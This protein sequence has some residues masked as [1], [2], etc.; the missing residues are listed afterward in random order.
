MSDEPYSREQLGDLAAFMAIADARSF[1]KAAARLGVSPSALSHT[2]RRLETR[3]GVRLLTRTTRKVMPT[4]AGDRLIATLGPALDD[5]G[6]KLASLRQ[7]SDAPSGDIRITL[8][9]HAA[10]TL[11]WPK[12]K[13]LAMSYPDIKVELDISSSLRDIVAERFDAG[14]RLGENVAKD[15]IGV[16]VGPRYSMAAVASPDYWRKYGKPKTPRELAAHN[17]I[18]LRFA[19]KGVY[20]WELERNGREQHLRVGGQITLNHSPLIIDAAL[21]GLG[22]GF[23]MDDAVREHLASGRL[24]RVLQSYCP[25]FSGYYLYYPSRRQLSR[26]MRLFVD[27]VRYVE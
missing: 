18:N 13:Q 23:V 19:S 14:V 7:L 4:D 16:K 21:S 3:L 27:A 25:P 11:V 22:V 26:V 12:V 24:E 1:T 15:M 5:I 10:Q 6:S 17:C 8:S 9:L 2:V 20:A